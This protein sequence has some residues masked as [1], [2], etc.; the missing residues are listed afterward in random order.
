MTNI[1]P[2][3][4]GSLSSSGLDPLLA[5][6][7]TRRWQDRLEEIRDL[8]TSGRRAGQALRQRHGVELTLEKLRRNPGAVASLTEALLGQYAIEIPRIAEQ[9]SDR[10]RERLVERLRLGL[11]G[12][13]TLVPLFHLIRTAISQ[14]DRG[15]AVAFSGLDEETPHD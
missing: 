8:A 7:G 12:Q 9:L 14:R 3:S 5:L 13:N 1:M 2:V 10:G 15:F 4:I 11:S 6:V